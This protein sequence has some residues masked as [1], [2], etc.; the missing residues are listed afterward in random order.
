[1]PLTLEQYLTHLDGRADLNWPA[2]PVPEPAKAKPYLP[3]L[4]GIKAIL[5]EVYGT[6]LS[7]TGGELLFE[8]PQKLVTDVALDKTISEFKMWASMSRKPGQPAEY[9]KVIF[10]KVRLDLQAL[11]GRERYPEM[12]SDRIWEEIIKK[13]MQKEYTFNAA[14][15]GSL[16]EF[17]R[18]VAY[19]YHASLQGVAAQPNALQAMRFAADCRLSQ[20]LLGDGQCFTAAQLSRALRIHDPSA[21]FDEWVPASHRFLSADVKAKKPSETLF[22]HALAG[23]ATKGIQPGE[24]LHIG[25]RLTRDIAPAKKHGMKAGLYVGDKASLDAKAELLKDPAHRPD[26]LLTDLAQVEQLFG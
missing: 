6:L 10:D 1:M 4:T 20:G 7:I 3:T 8:H 12:L 21:T 22:R 9:M 25:T 13:L 16:N 15:F 14:F 5:W 24:I 11:G 26:V 23:L 19:F 17:S 2:A 18:K